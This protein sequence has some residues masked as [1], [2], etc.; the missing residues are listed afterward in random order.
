MDMIINF[1]AGDTYFIS[2][3]NIAYRDKI[4]TVKT[5]AEEFG[6]D[7]D[8]KE[9]M[10]LLKSLIFIQGTNRFLFMDFSKEEEEEFLKEFLG[11]ELD[12]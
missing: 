10:K 12:G 1:K 5:Y 3:V 11:V 4:I 6:F 7:F 2:S 9:F 8:D